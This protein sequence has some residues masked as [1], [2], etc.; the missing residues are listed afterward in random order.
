MK[1][2]TLKPKEEIIFSWRPPRIIFNFI[3]AVSKISLKKGEKSQRKYN[4]INTKCQ[5]QTHKN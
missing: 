4:K 1:Q 2:T 5:E 3:I